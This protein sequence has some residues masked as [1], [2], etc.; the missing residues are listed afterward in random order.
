MRSVLLSFAVC[1]ALIL[2]TAAS[3]AN[4]TAAFNPEINWQQ[5]PPLYF[6]VTGGPPNTCGALWV[7]RNAGS[8]TSSGFGASGTGWL[9]TNGSGYAIKGPWFYNNQQGSEI[10]Y[11]YIEWPDGSTTTTAKHVWDKD[12]PAVSIG[13]LGSLP[14]QSFHGTATDSWGAG[15]SSSWSGCTMYFQD[16]DTGLHWTPGR[17]AYDQPFTKVNCTISGMPS[18]SVTWSAGTQFPPAGTHEPYHCYVWGVSLFDGGKWGTK[19]KFF[20]MS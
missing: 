19:E 15:F 4:G 13:Y 7:K 17:S 2:P 3:A 12:A 16:I 14:F 5:S 20:C 11:S 18:L 6:T 1:A 9:C 10:A 8:F